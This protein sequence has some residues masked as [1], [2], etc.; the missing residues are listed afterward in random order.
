MSPD[1]PKG[2]VPSPPSRYQ[3]PFDGRKTPI[4][5]GLMTPGPYSP[6]VGMSPC[7]PKALP[8]GKTYQVAV[9]GRKTVRSLFR[10]PLKSL[11]VTHFRLCATVLLHTEYPVSY[12]HLT[13]P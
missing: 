4:F 1:W 10:S 7:L 8:A 6:G 12:T 3:V 2:N 5:V 11:G 13:L 9:D